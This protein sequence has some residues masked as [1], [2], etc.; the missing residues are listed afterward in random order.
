VILLIN[1]DVPDII[2]RTQY[3]FAASIA[4]NISDPDYYIYAYCCGLRI[5]IIDAIKLPY[6][7]HCLCVSGI[8]DR[9]CW[10]SDD[11]AVEDIGWLGQTKFLSSCG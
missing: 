4:V 9:I 1:V 5:K 3:I 6:D 10:H 8:I 11:R 7:V 2:V